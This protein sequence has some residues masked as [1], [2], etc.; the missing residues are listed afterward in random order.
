M[1]V[2]FATLKFRLIYLSATYTIWQHHLEVRELCDTGPQFLIG[3][4]QHT[5]DS[6]QLV[7]L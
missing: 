5:E 6:E 7:N 2:I 4:P 1:L 3:S